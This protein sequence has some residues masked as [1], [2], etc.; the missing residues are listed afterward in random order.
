MRVEKVDP[1]LFPAVGK[2]A[3]AIT[4]CVSIFSFSQV[5]F[6]LRSDGAEAMIC[7]LVPHAGAS[8]LEV[9]ILKSS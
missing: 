4:I 3:C 1:T 5:V 6:E 2:A 9:L 7:M 8:G